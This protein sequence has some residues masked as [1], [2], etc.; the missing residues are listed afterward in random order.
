VEVLL[1]EKVE[2]ITCG[3]I[4]TQ[5]RSLAAENIIWAAGV[6][7]HPL[8]GI[9]GA[10]LDRG[11]RVKVNPELNLPDDERV[12]CLGDMAHVVDKAGRSLP[13]VAPVA[14]QQGKR[15]A[16]NIARLQAGRKA[17]PFRY[18]DKGS[19][20]TIGRKSAVAVLPGGILLTGWTAW[21]GWL[22]IHLA[23]LVDLQNRILVIMRWAWAYLGWKW[24]VRLIADP[25]R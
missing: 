7:G 25:P 13:G 6:E 20:A 2:E 23:F 5:C 10:P 14:V 24:N 1:N 9:L 21:L 22:A 8:A 16:R 17:E 11:G 15:A 12:F 4:R 3:L 18:F 19:M